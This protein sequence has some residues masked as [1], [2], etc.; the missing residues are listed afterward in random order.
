M[1][2]NVHQMLAF[3][4]CLLFEAVNDVGERKS[5]KN[6]RVLWEAE[7]NCWTGDNCL[8]PLVGV[9]LTVVSFLA[10]QHSHILYHSFVSKTCVY[11]KHC[12]YI[13][14]WQT[15]FSNTWVLTRFSVVVSA[16]RHQHVQVE[17]CKLCSC[18]VLSEHKVKQYTTT[19]LRVILSCLSLTEHFNQ[20][21][22]AGNANESLLVLLIRVDPEPIW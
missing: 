9:A 4:V 15:P 18:L 14:I 13:S 3:T 5:Q 11:L 7:G 19:V 8:W 21:A 16:C 1:L 12:W 2:P 6:A 10:W 22:G 20:Q 17:K